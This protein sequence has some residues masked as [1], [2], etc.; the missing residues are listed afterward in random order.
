VSITTGT[1]VTK[2]LRVPA[3]DPKVGAP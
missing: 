2:V 1:P 3:G